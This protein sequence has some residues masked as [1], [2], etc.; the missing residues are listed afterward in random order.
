MNDYLAR[1]LFPL[2]PLLVMGRSRMAEPPCKPEESLF[3]CW[4]V[5]E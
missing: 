4:K 2:R 1:M 5:V 3:Y